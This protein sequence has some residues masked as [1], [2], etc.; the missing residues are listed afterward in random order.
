MPRPGGNARLSFCAHYFF[1]RD[2]T[3]GTPIRHTYRMSQRT[4]TAK[5]ENVTA[6]SRP[7]QHIVL[8][9]D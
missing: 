6:P 5:P 8:V 4:S 9:V 1:E 3:T 7:P 2:Q